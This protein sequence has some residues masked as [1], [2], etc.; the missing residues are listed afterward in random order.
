METTSSPIRKDK[1]SE[2]R[3]HLIEKYP[4]LKIPEKSYLI[5]MSPRSGSTL[6]C[7]HLIKIG[8]GNPMEG[9]NVSERALK[10][11]FGS[12]IDFLNPYEHIQAALEKGSKN[13]VFGLKLSWVQFELFLKKARELIVLDQKEF[14]D[15]DILDLF[16]PDA[17]FILLKRRDK[18]QQ[19]VSFSKAMQTGI[20]SEKVGSSQEYKD[21]VRPAEYYHDHIEALFD[22]L[23]AFDLSWEMLLKKNQREYLEIWYEDLAKDY[24]K[25]VT[26]I[27]DY[28]DVKNDE[29]ITPFLQKQFDDKSQQWI[30]RFNHESLW[31]QDPIIRKGLENGDLTSIF[32]QRSVMNARRHERNVWADIPYNKFKELKRLIFRAKK[33]F[34]K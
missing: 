19:A 23:L 28:L 4:L 8:Y 6:L 34:G 22:N 18:V 26:E 16:F 10:E 33:R 21:Y 25:T 14:S 9:F 2:I 24:L 20:W 3:A 1:L 30:E 17:K 5:L 27:C 11:N 29:E 31:L 13:G 12:H 7:A 32:F 15:F